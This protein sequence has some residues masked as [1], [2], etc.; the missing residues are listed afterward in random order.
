MDPQ[1]LRRLLEDVAAGATPVDGALDELKK[2]P[3]ADHPEV[4]IDH[5]RALRCGFAEVV[6]CEGKSRGP[7]ALAWH[8]SCSSTATCSSARGR[9]AS[10]YQAARA[11]RLTTP[12]SSSRHISS[13][14]TGAR[15]ARSSVT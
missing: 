9:R 4:K 12:A 3:F 8:A 11:G 2:L 1:H 15:N 10:H 5:H 6:L 13:W 7:G 14:S